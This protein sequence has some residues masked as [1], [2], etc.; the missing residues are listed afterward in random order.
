MLPF[1]NPKQKSSLPPKEDFRGVC[2]GDTKTDPLLLE[3]LRDLGNEMDWA[4]FYHI[5]QR[6]IY[7]I[8]LS[9][10]LAKADALDI[11]QM[12]M[13]Q[14]S[15]KLRDFRYD[16]SKSFRGYLACLTY[17]RVL[18]WKKR[19]RTDV[20]IYTVPEES[21]A[22][23]EDRHFEKA[24]ERALYAAAMLELKKHFVHEHLFMFD[25]N[26]N[27]EKTYQETARIM[28][29]TPAAVAMAIHRVKSALKAQMEELVKQGF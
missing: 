24:S 12:V 3:G 19:E 21:L 9:Y 15:A 10:G 6:M 28:Q 7:S 20:D 26:M 1:S 4:R 17:S 25:L 16:P 13:V 22:A 2:G 18:D 5:Y 27:H 14:L 29:T 8:A 23:P 11:V